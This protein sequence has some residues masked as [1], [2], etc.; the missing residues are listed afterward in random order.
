[1]VEGYRF[2]HRLKVRYS[3]ID[4]QKIVFNA[5][6]LT[7]LDVAVSEYFQEGLQLDI[8]ELAENGQFDFV[9]AKTTLE[10]KSPARLGEWLT[11][12]CRMG[13]IGKTSMT[14]DFIITREGE[15]APLLLAEIIYVSYNPHTQSS[16]LVPDFIR[17]RIE[18]FEK[19]K[20]AG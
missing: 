11:I 17:E 4:G 7:Y 10:Y 2:S 1:M 13:K 5:H 8:A 9:L 15:T 6:Y 20:F 12:W 16:E 18:Q 3:E 14:M 19:G